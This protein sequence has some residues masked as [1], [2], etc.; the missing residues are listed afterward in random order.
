MKVYVEALW[1]DGTQML[2]NGDGQGPIDARDYRRTLAYKNVR[3]GSV[4][5]R[6]ATYRI[7]TPDNRVLE[8][9]AN[10]SHS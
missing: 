2:G 3:S 10:P 6:P 5:R 7:V 1:P 9:F 8:T 4:S